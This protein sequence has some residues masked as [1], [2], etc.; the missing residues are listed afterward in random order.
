MPVRERFGDGI[1]GG[2]LY[3]EDALPFGGRWDTDLD[4]SSFVPALPPGQYSVRILYHNAL[5][6]S[7]M[8]DVDGLAISHSLPITLVVAPATADLTK[9]NRRE[10]LKLLHQ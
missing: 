1:L 6:I 8:W 4:M 3:T 7:E 2:G 5:C 9:P 10:V